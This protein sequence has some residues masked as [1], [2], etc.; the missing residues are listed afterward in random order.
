MIPQNI[1]R[2]HILKAIEEAE[3]SGIPRERTSDSILWNITKSFTHLNILFHFDT[4]Y[5]RRSTS[6]KTVYH[7]QKFA[8]KQRIK[9]NVT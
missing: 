9:L 5:R 7:K 6:I 3:R 8:K 4:S 1:R 2:E